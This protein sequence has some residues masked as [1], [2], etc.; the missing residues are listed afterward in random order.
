MTTMQ[1]FTITNSFNPTLEL[2]PSHAGMHST[3]SDPRPDVWKAGAMLIEYVG[4]VVRRSIVD[5]RERREYDARVGAGTY[6]FDLSPASGLSV[7]AT[8]VRRR[9][10]RQANQPCLAIL[11]LSV[12]VA[13]A[14][15][16]ADALFSHVPAAAYF[17]SM[18]VG[19][20][21]C[22]PWDDYT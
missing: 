11:L 14:S 15:V 12:R 8:R 13:I 22:Q 21:F 5:L 10:W 17:L 3:W 2:A 18:S 19:N 6:V 1:V 16:I 9:H 7:D 4:E 20:A